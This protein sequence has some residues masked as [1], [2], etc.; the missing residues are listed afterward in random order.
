M[1]TRPI[2]NPNRCPTHPGEIL[3][4]IV[5]PKIGKPKTELADMLGIS[6]QTLYD[7][8][9]EKQPVTPQ[10]AVR[11]G[12]LLG[13]GPRMWVNMQAA[14]DLWHATREVDVSGIPT[15]EQATTKR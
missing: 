5:L 15:L 12:K 10:M 8:I 7:I 6:R 3:R 11:L 13:N 4:E 2:R 14:H 1:K 9:G